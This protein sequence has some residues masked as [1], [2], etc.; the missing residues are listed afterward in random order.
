MYISYRKS[1]V[2]ANKVDEIVRRVNEGLVPILY[3]A[4][5][6]V[7]Y[8]IFFDEQSYLCSVSMFTTRAAMEEANASAAEW[9]EANLGELLKTNIVI[10]QGVSLLERRK[11]ER[12]T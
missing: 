11:I 1:K 6:F 9:A 12:L 4:V 2:D 7:S 8:E 3:N 10:S 5:G